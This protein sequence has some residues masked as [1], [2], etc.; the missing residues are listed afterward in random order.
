LNEAQVKFDE[1]LRRRGL[2][3]TTE[4]RDI[5]DAILTHEDHFEVEE[6]LIHM[7]NDS[8]RV[9]RATIY[10]AVELLRE[11]GILMR[12]ELGRNQVRYEHTYKKDH[13]GFHHHLVCRETGRIQEFNSLDLDEVLRRICKEHDFKPETMRVVVTGLSAEG[14]A[15]AEEARG[16]G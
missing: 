13:P 10:R 12:V 15:R 3:L 4:R 8:K 6:L 2:K 16:H 14:R 7:R 11:A 9:S 5:L 1:F